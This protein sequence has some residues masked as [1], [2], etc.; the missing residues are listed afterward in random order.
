MGIRRGTGIVLLAFG[1]LGMMAFPT[2][3]WAQAGERIGTVLA[4]DGT[5]EAQAANTT[6]W[7]PLQFRAAI[8]QNATVRTG[9]DSKVKVLLRDD[10]IMTLA[11]RSEIQFTEFLLTPQQRRTVVSLALGKLRVVTTKIF[12]AGSVTEVRTAN[13]V[14]G[15]RGTSFIVIFIPPDTTQVLSL[16]GVVTVSHV[17][18]AIPQIE[19]VPPNFRTQVKGATAPARAT[20][21]SPAEHQGIEQELRLTEQVPTEVQTSSERQASASTSDLSSPLGTLPSQMDQ[22][23]LALSAASLPSVFG[24]PASNTIINNQQTLSKLTSPT[25][26]NTSPPVTPDSNPTANAIIQQ[27]LTNLHLTIKIPR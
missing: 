12:G 23:T 11:E 24:I 7:E 2:R 20:V 5:A 6:T 26:P 25:P 10:S 27:Q 21:L 17:N 8:F 3:G 9:A 14:A 15:V 4:V 18:P 16:E 22:V 19:P 13:T 1:I